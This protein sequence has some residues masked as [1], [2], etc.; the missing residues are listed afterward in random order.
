MSPGAITTPE[1]RTAQGRLWFRAPIICGT[2]L[3][4]WQLPAL[5]LAVPGT[6]TRLGLDMAAQLVAGL[7]WGMQATCV[8]M[9]GSFY[10]EQ[11]GF[12]TA[13]SG[14]VCAMVCC[15]DRF[16]GQGRTSDRVGKAR[17]FHTATVMPWIDAL[18]QW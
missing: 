2:G 7:I 4:G 17:T 10:W 15:F 1:D 13:V 12:N 18:K 5:A 8:P 14:Y 11:R 3:H 16:T 6:S 9:A